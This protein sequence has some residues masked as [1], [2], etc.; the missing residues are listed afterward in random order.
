[1]VDK[2]RGYWRAMLNQNPEIRTRVFGLA[3]QK[4]GSVAELARAMGLSV[5]QIYRV[6]EGMRRINQ[7]FIVG[8]LQAFPDHRMGQLFYVRHAVDD[9]PNPAGGDPQRQ[10]QYMLNLCRVVA[11]TLH[12]CHHLQ[13]VPGFRC[14]MELDCIFFSRQVQLRLHVLHKMI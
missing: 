8:A 5:S 1:M 6:R 3:S 9:A 11:E 7:K 14:R 4:Y 13:D 2:N 10:Y 12:R